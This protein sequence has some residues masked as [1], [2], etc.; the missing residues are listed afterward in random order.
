MHAV[1]DFVFFLYAACNNGIIHHLVL[2]VVI[3][4]VPEKLVSGQ[5][6]LL[7]LRDLSI[8]FHTLHITLSQYQTNHTTIATFVSLIQTR[9]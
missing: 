5:R 8:T 1:T 9:H 7:S 4:L 3:D 6:G 2:V